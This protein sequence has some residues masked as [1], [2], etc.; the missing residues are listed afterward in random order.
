MKLLDVILFVTVYL[1]TTLLLVFHADPRLCLPL[2]AWLF[3]YIGILSHIVPQLKRISTLQ[4]DA[5]SLMTGRI[6]DSYSNILTLKL[7]SQSQRESAYAKA[8][9][10]EFMATVYP[11]MRLSTQ[12]NACVWIINM[13][14]VFVTGDW[15]S[16]YGCKVPSARGYSDSHEFS[17]PADRH[18]TL[19][20]VGSQCTI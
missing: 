2:V 4:A 9:M 8:G 5:R 14:L 13:L 6:V 11:Q 17:Y 7:F 15:V 20:H 12:L 3:L 1:T 16:I 10:E 18:V 19:G